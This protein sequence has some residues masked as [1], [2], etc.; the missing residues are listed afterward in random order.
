[1][2]SAKL[3]DWLQVVGLF[4]VIASLLFV[5]MQMKQDRDIAL[6]EAF[7]TRTEISLSL[8][9]DL[10]NNPDLISALAKVIGEDSS[11]LSREEEILVRSYVGSM[12]D[13]YENLHFQ[14]S[15]GFIDKELW[16]K[17]RTNIKTT[18]L[19]GAGRKYT[20]ERLDTVAFRRSFAE[21]VQSIADEAQAE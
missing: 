8:D 18:L 20:L 17:A 16:N 21:L 6:S 9:S 13:M 3:N 11:M 19:T 2:D 5:G 7:Q 10:R 15:N 4:G 12:L 1:M 14:Y